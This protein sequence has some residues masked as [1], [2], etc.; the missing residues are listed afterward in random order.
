MVSCPVARSQT[1]R[2]PTGPW[3]GGSVRFA[4]ARGGLGLC[5]FALWTWQLAPGCA[6]PLDLDLNRSQQLRRR[7]E[8]LELKRCRALS[9]AHDIHTSLQPS[10]APKPWRGRDASCCSHAALWRCCRRGNNTSAVSC[11]WAGATRPYVS[12]VRDPTFRCTP[13][14]RHAHRRSNHRSDAGLVRGHDQK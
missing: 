2:G 9:S 8:P 6:L 12:R 4:R 10:T 11:A 14:T 5:H 3:R 13:S 1:Y 7:R